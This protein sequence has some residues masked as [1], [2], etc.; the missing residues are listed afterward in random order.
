MDDLKRKTKKYS[1]K[2]NGE[3]RFGV[4]KQFLKEKRVYLE[5]ATSSK[6]EMSEHMAEYLQK[7]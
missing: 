2:T 7:C 4:G 1:S 5:D 6:L 3:H